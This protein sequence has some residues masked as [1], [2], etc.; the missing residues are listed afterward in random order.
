MKQPKGRKV[1]V[2]NTLGSLGY[3]ACL[4]QWMW[5][6]LILLPA[7]LR[8]SFFQFITSTS[9]VPPPTVVVASGSTSGDVP[10]LVTAIAFIL[11]GAIILGSL[12][13]ILVKLPRSVAKTGEKVTHTVA[14]VITPVIIQHIHLPS[15]QRRQLPVILIVIMKFLLV[16]IPLCLLFFAEGQ[17][18]SMSFE[19]IMIIGFALF[20]WSFLLFAVQFV[21][22]RLLYVDYKTIR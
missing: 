8:S 9:P 3:V 4:L 6:L 5:M 15:K 2:L 18:L 10:F 22:S 16:F 1:T 20:S 7:I 14:T 17:K 12:Y 11:A 21:L 13:V 19:V